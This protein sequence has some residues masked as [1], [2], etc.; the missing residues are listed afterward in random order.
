M[1]AVV[2]AVRDLLARSESG[3]QVYLLLSSLLVAR[4]GQRSSGAARQVCIF[5]SGVGL[6]LEIEHRRI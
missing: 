4:M 2:V 3:T 1:I 5:T 6:E